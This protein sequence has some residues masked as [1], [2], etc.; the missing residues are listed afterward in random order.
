MSDFLTPAPDVLA[1]LQPI[2]PPTPKPPTPELPLPPPPYTH[3]PPS[4]PLL[5]DLT[6]RLARAERLVETARREARMHESLIR[7]LK[8]QLQ[9][10]TKACKELVD[11]VMEQENAIQRL[12]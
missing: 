1:L 7:D 11:T 10:S 5:A 12:I 9:A 2:S 4:D 3:P 6:S 8:S